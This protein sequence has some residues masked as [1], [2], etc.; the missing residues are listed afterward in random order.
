MFRSGG[1]EKYAECRRRRS[2]PSAKQRLGA[3]MFFLLRCVFWLTV[4][5]TTI[6]QQDS[7][8][9]K[10]MRSDIAAHA[11]PIERAAAAPSAVELQ[12]PA[13]NANEAAQAWLKSA[14]ARIGSD[15]AGRCLEAP[16]ECIASLSQAPKPQVPTMAKPSPEGRVAAQKI[17]SLTPAGPDIPLPPHRP[18]ASEMAAMKG[19]SVEASMR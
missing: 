13:P 12:P 17:A 7:L 11:Q 8:R 9:Q 10:P 19:R 18:P 14:I 4:V 2:R 16:G 15:L 1:G 5:F 6:F 3:P